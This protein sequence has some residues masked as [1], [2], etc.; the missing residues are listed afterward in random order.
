MQLVEMLETKVFVW[1]RDNQIDF[2]IKGS[3]K[4]TVKTR[5]YRVEIYALVPK[6]TSCK[7]GLK[8]K[9]C[10]LRIATV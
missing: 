10:S 5:G 6:V 8:N 3:I 7:V 1:D 2:E 4:V 9:N